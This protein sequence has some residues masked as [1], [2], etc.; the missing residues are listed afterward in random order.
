MQFNT[1]GMFMLE[2]CVGE[3]T[4][5]EHHLGMVLLEEERIKLSFCLA[6]DAADKKCAPRVLYTLNSAQIK[7]CRYK[8]AQGGRKQRAKRDYS[9]SA[10]FAQQYVI[11]KYTRAWVNGTSVWVIPRD[12]FFAESL[13]HVL[14]LPHTK[15]NNEKNLLS[16][17]GAS[18]CGTWWFIVWTL[19]FSAREMYI[20][21]KS[22][23]HDV[24]RAKHR[25]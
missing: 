20:Y 21:I 14:Y 5:G 7:K 2:C 13:I 17:S 23:K 16:L 24:W 11:P 25:F 8:N 22:I 3:F 19:R 4:P 12:F 10:S 9:S 18:R 6:H 15:A 1:S